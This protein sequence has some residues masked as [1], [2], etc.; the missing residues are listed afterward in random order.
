[1]VWETSDDDDECAKAGLLAT[2]RATCRELGKF[3]SAIPCWKEVATSRERERRLF[4]SI[5]I[6]GFCDNEKKILFDDDSSSFFKS[7]ELLDSSLG[8]LLV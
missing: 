5:F 1:M 4:F 7:F 2:S 8:N 3:F 6:R